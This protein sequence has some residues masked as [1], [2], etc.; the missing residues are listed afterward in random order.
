MLNNKNWITNR[1][2]KLEKQLDKICEKN[3]IINKR[4]DNIE[5]ENKYKDTLKEIYEKNI[6]INNKLEDIK[7]QFDRI[8]RENKKNGLKLDL[9]LSQLNIINK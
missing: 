6:I 9:I 5:N 8:E 7:N 2:N 3:I 4:L 1:Q